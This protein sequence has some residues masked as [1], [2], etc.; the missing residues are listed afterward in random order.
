[1][2]IKVYPDQPAEYVPDFLFTDGTFK[3]KADYIRQ[4]KA[5]QKTA[6][7]A[8]TQIKAAARAK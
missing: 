4:S 5:S 6:I 2:R 7:R 3:D 8:I 1:M